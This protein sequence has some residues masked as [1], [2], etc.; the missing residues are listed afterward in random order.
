MRRKAVCFSPQNFY[1]KLE[2]IKR[3]ELTKE[4]K[5]YILLRLSRLR[6]DAACA[7]ESRK[8]RYAPLAQLDRASVYGTEG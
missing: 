7:D 5:C 8:I 1:N 6:T 2:K 3:K 4:N